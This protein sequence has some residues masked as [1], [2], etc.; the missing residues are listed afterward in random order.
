MSIIGPRETHDYRNYNLL[1]SGTNTPQTPPKPPRTKYLFGC[2][3]LG[4]LALPVINSCREPI[5]SEWFVL[6]VN[7][8]FGVC[9]NSSQ[10]P[11]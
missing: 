7:S 5:E 10:L 11:F 6:E 8:R 3:R 2:A 4:I 9:R 1:G